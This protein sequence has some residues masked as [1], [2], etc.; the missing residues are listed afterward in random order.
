MADS[1]ICGLCHPLPPGRDKI[2][3]RQLAGGVVWDLSEFYRGDD[4]PFIEKDL[5]KACQK[6]VAFESQYKERVTEEAIDAGT[7]L[8]A[9]KEYESIHETVMWPYLFAFLYQASDTQDD[10]RNKLLQR[11]REERNR[12]SLIILFFPLQLKGLSDHLLNELAGSE[13][14]KNYRYYIERLIT[15]KPH[16]LSEP[17]E[18]IIKSK[19]L[20]GRKTLT[21]LFTELTGS[22]SSFVEIGG[23]QTVE[24]TGAEILTL[25]NSSRDR[26]VREKAYKVFLKKYSERGTVFKHIIN[27]L[28]LDRTMDAQR[29]KHP[30]P[31]HRALLLNKVDE[32]A[33]ETM[34]SVTEEYYH[35]AR[36]YFRFKAQ[37]LGLKKL[38]NTDI[39]A[40]MPEE[41]VRIT[42]A[43]ARNLILDSLKNLHPLF[44]D[45]ASEFFKNR[46]IDAEIRKGKMDGA[47]CCS[48]SPAI[49]PFIHLNYA[50]SLR[51]VMVLAHEL[52]HGIHF[53]LASEQTHLNFR[54][55]P[56]LAETASL[57]SEMALTHHLLKRNEFRRYHPMILARQIETII[58]TVFR[59]NVLTRFEQAIYR[60]R[61]RGLMSLDDICHTWWEENYQLFSKDVEMIPEYRWGWAY[62]P[63]FIHFNFY[64]FSYIFG[65]LLS[66]ILFQKFL[67]KGEDVTEDIIT[68][69]RSGGA[70]SPFD[71]L[72]EI[73][74]DPH[75]R[76]FWAS[77]FDYIAHMI[78][79]LKG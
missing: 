28:V 34:I 38:K 29:R 9:L 69:L 60:L 6:A 43:D 35:L 31:M 56:V 61:E 48:P 52:G 70:R 73:G 54:P 63:H 2:E 44:V 74:L 26:V 10:R 71:L 17:E 59:Q 3:W 53:L 1:R 46:W 50:G 66:M 23:G 33:I 24:M 41:D 8:S 39:F 47:F 64:C 72:A 55:P 57:L 67:K 58:V 27:A 30:S 12:I 40:P 19:N 16:T 4:D 65:G 11:V 5:Q 37:N 77:G 76:S 15:G 79:M 20:T 36:E 21:S 42:F 78:H 32:A 62:I 49:H 14:L 22:F 13:K 25:V 68:I 51:D 7:L 75:K 18:R 45:A